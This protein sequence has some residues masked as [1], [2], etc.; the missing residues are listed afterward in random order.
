MI[1]RGLHRITAL[2]LAA[3]MLAAVVGCGSN[4]GQTKGSTTD[5]TA[6]D[7]VNL[8]LYLQYSDD[9]EKVPLDYAIA[10]MKK[11]MPEVE[12]EIMPAA[13]DD[14][15]KLKTLAAAG[16]LPDIFDANP[17]I[18]KTFKKS[19]NILQLDSYVKEL[20]IEDQLLDSTKANLRDDEGH[21]YGIPSDAPWFA[22][23]YYNKD[24]FQQNGLQP[25]ANFNEL[26]DVVEK[27][28]EKNIIPLS[29]FA[30]E[31]WPGVQLYDMIATRMDPKG[32][33]DLDKGTVMASDP[34]F[35]KTADKIRQLVS[36][37]M[38]APGVFNTGYDEALSLF[39]EGKAAM[40][41]NGG[42]AVQ[43]LGAKMPGK[44]GILKY[45]F[46]DPGQESATANQ[47]SGGGTIGGLGV[48]P[49]SEHKDIA[50]K[51]A[52]QLSLKISEGRVLKRGAFPIVKNSVQPEEPYTDIQNEYKAYASQAKSSSAFTFGMT[53]PTI[54]TALEDNVQKLL[55]GGYPAKDFIK[56][57]DAAIN[58]A[59]K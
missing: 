34:E 25:P 3:V 12:A 23:L 10:E 35:S 58:R 5:K 21:I 9:S 2:S 13:R 26:L 53:N 29:L 39:V 18:I 14:N 46:A 59:R 33:S 28:K 20:N 52:I 45:P 49:N 11:V 44:A 15:Q 55:A 4:S 42:W 19:N 54:K 37:G 30:K 27:L 51:Y 41:L 32:I 8:K 47:M 16:N 36:A 57:M 38:L 1:N 17:D 7:K 40:L 22:M 50:A 6:S 48:S 43:D 24:V 31:K 56:D